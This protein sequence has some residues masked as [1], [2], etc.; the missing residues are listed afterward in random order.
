MNMVFCHGVMGPESD[1]NAR[2]YNPVKGWKDWLQFYAEFEH[3]VVMQRPYFPHAH[4]L[5]MKYEEWEKIM[6]RQEIGPDTVL[7]GH[8]AGGGFLLKY[9]SRHPKLRVKQLVL[10]APWLDAEGFQP[11]GFYKD[12]KLGDNIVAQAAK[13]ID[14]LI[15]DDDAPYIKSSF[16]KIIENM[17][18][19]HVHKFSNRGH[20]VEPELPEIMQIIH[21]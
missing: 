19:I 7:V 5:L 11:N 12:I 4:V 16:D 1:W 2:P 15:S 8:S 10:V 6:D 13:G 3:D 9:L 21:W 18:N 17:P 20:F 14:L